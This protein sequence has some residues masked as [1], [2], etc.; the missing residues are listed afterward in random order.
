MLKNLKAFFNGEIDLSSLTKAVD[1]KDVALQLIHMG[2]NNA[3]IKVDNNKK[4]VN[5]TVNV[6]AKEV[7][8]NPELIA[9]QLSLLIEQHVQEENKPVLEIEASDTVKEIEGA[10]KYDEYI[11]FFKGKIADRDLLTLRA[12]Y[13][14][15]QEMEGGKKVERLVHGVAA[16]YG[17]R[18]TNIVNLCGRGY[19]E[20]YIKPLYE[21]LEENPNFELS[22]FSNM[23]NLIIETV[24]FAYFVNRGQTLDNLIES[25]LEKIP[26]SKQY[27]Q[28]KLAIHAI[29]GDNVRKTQDAVADERIEQ[30]INPDDTDIELRKNILTLTI[31]FK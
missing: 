17:K 19:F 28:K 14:I 31:Y 22:T 18:G 6:D 11:N 24:P 27:G 13:F 23:Y 21:T 5:L 12:A 2:Q 9:R 8:S 25:L 3:F 30:L 4:T 10:T 15:R 26:F 29:G 7:S 16:N 20:D 1:L